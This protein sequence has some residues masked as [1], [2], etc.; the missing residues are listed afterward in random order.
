MPN[1][2]FHQFTHF[3]VIAQR[4]GPHAFPVVLL[5]IWSLEV[6]VVLS[7]DV[8]SLNQ[9]SP[10]L[11]CHIFDVDVAIC[12]PGHSAY[13]R[14]TFP[15]GSQ[16][17]FPPARLCSVGEIVTILLDISATTSMLTTLHALTEY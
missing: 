4:E 10:P 1:P 15:F 8:T 13:S 6:Y 5:P 12:S 16:D 2:W 3:Q 14:T 17:S 7:R 11:F 9:T